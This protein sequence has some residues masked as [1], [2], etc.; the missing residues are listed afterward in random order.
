MTTE[1]KTY[2]VCDLAAGF[3]YNEAEGKGLY[4]LNGILT[5]QPE[6]QR[7]YIYADGKKDKAV[8]DTLV[9]GCPVG[10]L[11][12]NVLDET[13][14]GK[15]RMEVLDG[16]QRITSIG[17][18]VTGKFAITI[19]G[20]EY[21]YSSLAQDV[22]ERIDNNE[23]AV[24]EC[25]GTE[26]EIKD[27]FKMINIAGIPLNTQELLN[28]SYSGPF[29]TAARKEFSNSGNTAVQKWSAYIKGS[30]NRQDYLQAALQWIAAEK[31]L[32]SVDKYMSAHRQDESIDELKKYFNTVIDWAESTFT[33]PSQ[34]PYKEMCGLEW[35][36]LYREY[37]N[38]SYNPSEVEKRV[39]D[40]M[41]ADDNVVQDKR[42]I[43][44]YVLS[45]ENMPQL[46]NI[47]IF[48]D[49]AKKTVYNK[50]TQEAKDKGVSNC[51]LCALSDT[52]NKTKIWKLGEM[53]ADHV[54]AWSKGGAT[55]IA[56]CQML[57]KTHNRA[58]GNR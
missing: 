31:G 38:K 37:H 33:S 44:E 34:P 3:F 45:G 5:I 32:D 21:T 11:Y 46:L 4:G 29:V 48:D 14:N 7:N 20:R 41:A 42:G 30:A 2:K 54:A 9:K 15:P 26:T 58:K 13:V 57:C 1:L 22:R 18:F 25:K 40:L 24:Y 47:R 51:P 16:Q 28:A 49:A 52:A 23:V 43:F 6:Y 27:W 55:N 8:I 53:D 56:N 35:G 50:Q 39:K 10:L 36:R 19:D 12:F 17:R